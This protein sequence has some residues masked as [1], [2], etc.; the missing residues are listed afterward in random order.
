MKVMKYAI[1]LHDP[2]LWAHRNQN[3]VF[4]GIH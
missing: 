3:R 4:V 2:T 1:P